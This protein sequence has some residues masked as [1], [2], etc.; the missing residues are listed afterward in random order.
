M[1]KGSLRVSSLMMSFGGGASQRS[2]A[3]E[4]TQ[5]QMIRGPRRPIIKVQ[6]LTSEQKRE[7]KES[8]LTYRKSDF[9]Q[10]TL[11]VALT[12][13]VSCTLLLILS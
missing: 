11:I 6:K 1:R 4:T 8:I 13:L 2:Y 10:T 5:N 3:F 7:V 9:K 12:V